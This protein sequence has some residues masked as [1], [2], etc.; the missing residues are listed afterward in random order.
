VRLI[1]S[2]ARKRKCSDTAPALPVLLSA[3]VL[4][5]KDPAKNECQI[6]DINKRRYNPRRFCVLSLILC[7]SGTKICQKF[8]RARL[9]PLSC[10]SETLVL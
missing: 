2:S 10:C 5:V 4:F 6:V 8:G 1:G 7:G 9:I 3:A